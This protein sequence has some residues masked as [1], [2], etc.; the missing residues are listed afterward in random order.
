MFFISFD[1]YTS[2]GVP[3]T[4]PYRIKRFAR[5]YSASSKSP[6]PFVSKVAQTSSVTI[7][8]VF[9][10]ALLCV[11]TYSANSNLFILRFSSH[12]DGG[13]FVALVQF[14]NFA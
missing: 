12:D 7:T 8:F 13:P 5:A 14:V 3:E 9:I 11:L 2:H 1:E 4:Y 10:N 6:S